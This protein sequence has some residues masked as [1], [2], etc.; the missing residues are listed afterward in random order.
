MSPA[1]QCE[2]Q[3]GDADLAH[4]E[5]L[6]ALSDAAA[7]V[8][9]VGARYHSGRDIANGIRCLGPQSPTAAQA[10]PEPM[11]E[12]PVCE[13]SGFSGRGTGYDDVCGECGGHGHYPAVAQEAKHCGE[14]VA[15]QAREKIPGGIWRHCDIVTDDPDFEF[16]PLYA[17]PSQTSRQWP[18]VFN[19]QR[20]A[21]NGWHGEISFARCPTNEELQAL[22]IFLRD[23]H[24]SALSV[25]SA[26]REGK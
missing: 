6:K 8:E 25:P 26:D 10:V 16:R 11:I 2:V 18:R 13:G 14:P 4:P 20:N 7:Y 1:P 3:S 19:V 23:D 5:R 15:W 24:Q 9:M 12:C 22:D 17:E 21:E